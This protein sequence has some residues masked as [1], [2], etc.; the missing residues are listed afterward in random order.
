MQTTVGKVAHLYGNSESHNTLVSYF[1]ELVRAYDNGTPLAE[2][3]DDDELWR[4][5]NTNTKYEYRIHKFTRYYAF[6]SD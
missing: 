4:I 3:E 2:A 6:L 5:Q 1:N